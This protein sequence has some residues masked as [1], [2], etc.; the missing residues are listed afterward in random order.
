M[1][2]QTTPADA[3]A[4]FVARWSASAAAE[5]AN[6]ALFLTELCDVLAV[7]ARP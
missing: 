4:T 1:S 2:D 7:P 6:Y 3:A 5:R